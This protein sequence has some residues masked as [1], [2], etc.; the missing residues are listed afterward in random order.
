[1]QNDYQIE[2]SINLKGMPMRNEDIGLHYNFPKIFIHLK[3]IS[4]T[5]LIVV[6]S[7]AWYLVSRLPI[8]ISSFCKVENVLPTI[9]SIGATVLLMIILSTTN[10]RIITASLATEREVC[11]LLSG[12]L[13]VLV[14]STGSV[15]FSRNLISST[16][17][18]PTCSFTEG[19]NG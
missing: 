19:R 14:Y 12:S 3:S 13:K 17:Q 6:L 2:K 9:R 8:E 11:I 16:I 18:F 5:A 10:K 4:L 1:M 7:G 15:P